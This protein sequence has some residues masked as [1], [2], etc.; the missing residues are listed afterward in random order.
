MVFGEGGRREGE[1][2][3]PWCLEKKDEERPTV[4]ERR[5]SCG[6]WKR[7]TKRGPR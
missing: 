6:V 4:R 2:G 3:L 7:R 5:A 1:E